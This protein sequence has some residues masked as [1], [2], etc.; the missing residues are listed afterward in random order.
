[1]D[2][3][4]AAGARANCSQ[5]VLSSNKCYFL[6]MDRAMGIRGQRTSP[7]FVSP[8]Q[9][10]WLPH[11]ASSPRTNPSHSFQLVP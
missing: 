6:L 2:A 1:M 4:T 8:M 9:K 5:V 11:L 10:K 3:R 7:F